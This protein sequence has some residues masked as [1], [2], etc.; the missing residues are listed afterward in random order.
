M[1]GCIPSCTLQAVVAAV[2]LTTQEHGL[3]RRFSNHADNFAAQFLRDDVTHT[4]TH[5]LAHAHAR[6]RTHAH[7][8]THTPRRPYVRTFMVE[9]KFDMYDTCCSGF[10]PEPASNERGLAWIT[11]GATNECNQCTNQQCATN[12]YRTGSCSISQGQHWTYVI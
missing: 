1:P 11:A 2:F 12:K 6:A 4:R 3:H 7:T 9:G 8:H 10:G 5:A